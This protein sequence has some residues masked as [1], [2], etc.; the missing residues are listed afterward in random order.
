V[1]STAPEGASVDALLKLALQV[2]Y[3]G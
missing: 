1:K 2:L 3:K